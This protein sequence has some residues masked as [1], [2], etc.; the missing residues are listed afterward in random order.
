M[1]RNLFE[2]GAAAVV[3]SNH[4]SAAIDFTVPSMIAL[5]KI[6]ESV[7]QKLTILVDTGFKTGSDVLEE[8]WPWVPK[9][10]GLPVRC[11][12]RMLQMGEAGVELLINQ[13]TAELRRTMAATGCADLSSIGRSIVHYLPVME[14]G[15]F[16]R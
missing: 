9:P 5:P 6:V 14:G 16:P 2:L 11:F 1:P 8:L 13:I 15:G 3:V 7:G 12:S 10:L 4:G